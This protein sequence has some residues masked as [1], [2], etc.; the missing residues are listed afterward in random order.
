M[1]IEKPIDVIEGNDVEKPK[2][3]PASVQRLVIRRF[4]SRPPTLPA[5]V[6]ILD[7]LFDFGNGLLKLGRRGGHRAVRP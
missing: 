6:L 7:V 2:R 1:N 5:A 4:G 3:E